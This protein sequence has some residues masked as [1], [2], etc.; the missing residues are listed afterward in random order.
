MTGAALLFRSSVLPFFRSSVLPFFRSSVLP[1]FRS[2]VA[3]WV[4]WAERR[5][6]EEGVPSGTIEA[7]ESMP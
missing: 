4:A 6:G 3:H 7:A 1:F 5:A 2:S